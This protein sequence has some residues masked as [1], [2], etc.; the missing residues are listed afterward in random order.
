MTSCSSPLIDE[1]SN[2]TSRVNF[3]NFLSL[4]RLAGHD[5]LGKA[6]VFSLRRGDTGDFGEEPEETTIRVFLRLQL[7][8]RL[9]RVARGLL[10]VGG[11]VV[12]Y[13][14]SSAANVAR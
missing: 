7:G 4:L 12:E 14:F 3:P 2:N 5:S 8:D 11:F 9:D 10:I 6:S 13:R 1:G